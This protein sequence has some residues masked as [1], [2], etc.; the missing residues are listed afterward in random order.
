MLSMAIRALQIR[1]VKIVD[2]RHKFVPLIQVVEVLFY[3]LEH[4][5]LLSCA[6]FG[7]PPSRVD[8]KD[9]FPYQNV[10]GSSVG[11]GV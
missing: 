3:A 2:Q 4:L 7:L 1:T 5:E 6:S 8:F 10:E 11:I 9:V